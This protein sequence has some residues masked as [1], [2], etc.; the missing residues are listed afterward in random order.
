MT[1][2]HLA[3]NVGKAI[4]MRQCEQQLVGAATLNVGLTLFEHMDYRDGQLTN[5]SFLEYMMPTFDDIPG[6]FVPVVLEEAHPNGPFGAKGV[7]ETGCIATTPAILN[8]IHD[9]VGVRVRDLP[10]TPE[11]V[12]RAIRKVKKGGASV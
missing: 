5:G 2:L 7:G 6:D 9:A 11:K 8:A 1:R 12:L 3:G 10:V 4:N